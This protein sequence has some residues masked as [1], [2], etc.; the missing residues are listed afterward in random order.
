MNTAM[1]RI[2]QLRNKLSKKHPS[3][4]SLASGSSGYSGS[5]GLSRTSTYS[6]SSRSSTFS[7]S[8]GLSRL[9]GGS[10]S[11]DYMGSFGMGRSSDTSLESTFFSKLSADE[12]LARGGS[13]VAVD[14][15]SFQQRLAFPSH[16]QVRKKFLKMS[17]NKSTK[18]SW[19]STE[20]V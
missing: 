20:T 14:A 15:L 10:R 8:S 16:I 11:S 17:R 3:G 12:T 18:Q 9:S 7:K 1:I 13:S 19:N 6:G 2:Y 4:A 5:S